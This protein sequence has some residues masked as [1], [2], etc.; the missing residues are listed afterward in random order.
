[1]SIRLSTALLIVTSGRNNKLS[2]ATRQHLATR[3]REDR[4]AHGS[5]FC[6]NRWLA[7]AMRSL[8]TLRRI[9]RGKW[10]RKCV[11]I[12]RLTGTRFKNQKR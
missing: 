5:E 7:S 11:R 8:F 12:G 1:M 4:T 9:H 3:L 2:P 10:Q 6:R